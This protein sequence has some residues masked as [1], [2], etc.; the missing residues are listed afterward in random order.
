MNPLDAF[1]Y[2]IPITTLGTQENFFVKYIILE[3]V[4][5][6]LLLLIFKD[7]DNEKYYPIYT[8]SAGDID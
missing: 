6:P 7:S 5:M 4:L 3:K 8:E 1:K 2:V